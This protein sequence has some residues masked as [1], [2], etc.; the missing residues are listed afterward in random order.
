MSMLPRLSS[1]PFSELSCQGWSSLRLPPPWISHHVSN[2]SLTL[3]TLSKFYKNRKYAI[4]R[5]TLPPQAGRTQC[6]EYCLPHVDRPHGHWREQRTSKR[7][8][9]PERASEC[10]KDERGRC[11]SSGRSRRAIGRKRRSGRET[12]TI[13]STEQIEDMVTEP[14]TPGKSYDGT[15]I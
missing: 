7:P 2:N 15:T 6:P 10:I 11:D 14:A 13:T 5:Q 1:L 9:T 8:H 3:W 12:T 4:L